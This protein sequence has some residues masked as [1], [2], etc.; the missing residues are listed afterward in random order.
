LV[1]ADL[2]AEPIEKE[3][4]ALQTQVEVA[5]VVVALLWMEE[6]VAQESSSFATHPTPLLPLANQHRSPLLELR[7][8]SLTTK[9]SPPRQHQ[10]LPLWSGAA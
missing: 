8:L 1:A 3:L 5:V 4:M 10:W 2:A 6:M 9:L 7:L